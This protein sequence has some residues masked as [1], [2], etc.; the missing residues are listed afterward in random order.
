MTIP[1]PTFTMVAPRIVTIASA[2]SSPGK[3]QHRV[4]KPH[5]DGVDDPAEVVR[6]EAHGRSQG[7]D[8]HDRD[9][10]IPE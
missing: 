8:R 9:Q 4:D 10:R 7:G 2:I 3:R 6:H 1:M 5:R